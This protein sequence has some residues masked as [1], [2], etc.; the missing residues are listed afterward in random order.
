MRPEIGKCRALWKSIEKVG[1]H[2]RPEKW[3]MYRTVQYSRPVKTILKALD[4]GYRVFIVRH[5]L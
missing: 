5:F 3:D 4:I 1:M 2:A